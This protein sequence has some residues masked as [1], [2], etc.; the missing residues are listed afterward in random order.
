M[1]K[2]QLFTISGRVQGVAFR[3]FTQR[4]AL[5]IGIYGYVKNLYNGD[6]EVYAI[7]TE[8]QLLNLYSYLRQGPSMANVQS[9]TKNDVKIIDDYKTFSIKY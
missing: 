9:I 7:G 8:E 1:K 4:I 3:Y 5:S 6:V 2:A